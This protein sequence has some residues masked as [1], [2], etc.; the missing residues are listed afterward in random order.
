MDEF[1]VSVFAPLS[2]EYLSE[3]IPDLKALVSSYGQRIG[4][5]IMSWLRAQLLQSGRSKFKYW[6]CTTVLLGML[7]NLSEYLFYYPSFF[8]LHHS[9]W[10]IME[11][12]GSVWHLS[13]CCALNVL[14]KEMKYGYINVPSVFTQCLLVATIFACGFT[15]PDIAVH[16][17]QVWSHMQGILEI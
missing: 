4:D 12:Y 10:T 6:F 1:A 13:F 5:R 16:L 9:R 15:W 11:Y 7:Q 3:Q 2:L 17:W 14:W 8:S